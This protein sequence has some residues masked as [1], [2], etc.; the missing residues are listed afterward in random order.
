MKRIKK[1][2]KRI[3]DEIC[4]AEYYAEKAIEYKMDG[5]TDMYKKFSQM[6]NE[7]LGHAMTIHD[8]AV[9]EID[10]VQSVITPPADM[11]EKWELAH[12]DYIERV[13]KI[14]SYINI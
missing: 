4:S 3:D 5:E 12:A 2:V 13:A 11:R 6:A 14:K 10:K 7:E 9:K 1:L 8:I